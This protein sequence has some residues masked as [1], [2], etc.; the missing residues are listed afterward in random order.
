MSDAIGNIHAMETFSQTIQQFIHGVEP[1]TYATVLAFALCF[2]GFS[3]L[4]FQLAFRREFELGG[5]LAEWASHLSVITAFAA[6]V[7]IAYGSIPEAFVVSA[8]IAI[9]ANRNCGPRKTA[10]P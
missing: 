10:K 1:S 2:E 6:A 7:G 8:P 4:A 9:L 3:K 5:I